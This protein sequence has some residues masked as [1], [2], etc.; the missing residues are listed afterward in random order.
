MPVR[1]LVSA[2]LLGVCCRYDSKSKP[3]QAVLDLAKK[4][5]LIPVCPE[6]LGGL[7]TPRPP[8]E[9]QGEYVRKADGGDVTAQYTK[10]A[11]EAARL[12]ELLDCD[13]A[14]LKSRSPSCGLG[15]I[16]D[17][18]FSGRLT[19]GNGVTAGLFRKKGINVIS[20]E[21]AEKISSL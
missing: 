10:G 1:I 13:L 7:A 4:H 9:I 8:A 15:E 18:S 17:G 3:C 6:Q 5:E 11:L 14:I 12:Y 19:A 21:D 16:Y 2:C 20:D